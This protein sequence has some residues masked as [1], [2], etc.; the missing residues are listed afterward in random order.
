MRKL[1]QLSAFWNRDQ[2]HGISITLG[3]AD[4]D[5]DHVLESVTHRLDA[6]Y[7]RAVRESRAAELLTDIY[8][9]LSSIGLADKTRPL[10][11]TNRLAAIGNIW[12][13]ERYGFLHPDEF[14]GLQLEFDD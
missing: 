8:S 11:R 6:L 9:A 2:P 3:A 4:G 10:P 12:L 7:A 13:L 14:N 1:T 5:L